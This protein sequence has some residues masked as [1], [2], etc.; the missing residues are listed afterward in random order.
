MAIEVKGKE[1]DEVN[2]DG[3]RIVG[4]K[5]KARAIGTGYAMF[6]VRKVKAK[7]RVFWKS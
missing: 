4:S 7:F 6:A 1:I 3:S 5:F 2:W